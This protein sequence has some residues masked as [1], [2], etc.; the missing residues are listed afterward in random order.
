MSIR[1]IR[2]MILK[3]YLNEVKLLL[4]R[5]KQPHNNYQMIDLFNKQIDRYEKL[6]NKLESNSVESFTS[7]ENQILNDLEPFIREIE[8]FESLCLEI[9][10]IESSIII[11]T[12]RE[13]HE[14]NNNLLKLR[15]MVMFI[16]YQKFFDKKEIW[17]RH[18]KIPEF[19]LPND[20]IGIYIPMILLTDRFNVHCLED[21]QKEVQMIMDA[22]NQMKTEISKKI[23]T[24]SSSNFSEICD[25]I[26]ELERIILSFNQLKQKIHNECLLSLETKKSDIATMN[27]YVEKNTTGSSLTLNDVEKNCSCPDYVYLRSL[28]NREYNV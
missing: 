19:L 4:D 28:L 2:E 15:A 24:I 14:K 18:P 22:F 9:S 11:E 5:E 7:D 23:Q 13:E 27:T 21:Y 8:R 17:S 10:K 26:N 3:N 6:I 20:L 12:L 1:D 25:Q 16:L